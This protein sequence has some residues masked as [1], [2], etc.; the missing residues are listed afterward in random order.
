MCRPVDAFLSK[1]CVGRSFDLI[2]ARDAVGSVVAMGCSPSAV[3][4]RLPA[5]SYRRPV[6]TF[7]SK[8]SV[9]CSFD[10]RSARGG[11]VASEVAG[12]P[13]ML[14]G[15][16]DDTAGRGD[17]SISPSLSKLEVRRSLDLATSAGEAVG[18]APAGRG[19]S[20]APV[21]DERRR[22]TAAKA[23]ESFGVERVP[24]ASEVASESFGV[25]RVPLAEVAEAPPMLLRPLDDERSKLG[26]IGVTELRSRPLGTSSSFCCSLAAIAASLAAYGS[27]KA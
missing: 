14:L 21:R 18:S 27:T 23:G 2:S 3:T 9:G 15:P 16:L 22:L 12:A 5:R 1:L 19:D 8:L 25:E 10:L 24:L 6:E 20:R 4:I 11:A 13:P 7:L 26:R 17:W